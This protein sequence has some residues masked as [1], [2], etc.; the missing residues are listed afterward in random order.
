MLM[1]MCSQVGDVMISYLIGEPPLAASITVWISAPA[2]K[3]GLVEEVDVAVEQ[4]GHGLVGVGHE[5][6]DDVRRGNI[7]R[8]STGSSQ[9]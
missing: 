1:S 6:D 7:T 9:R 3:R 4:L 5:D 8:A 2:P